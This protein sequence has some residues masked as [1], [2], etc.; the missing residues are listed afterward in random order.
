MKLY[1]IAFV[2]RSKN[3]GPFQVTIDLMFKDLESYKKIMDSAAFNVEKIGEL[4]NVAPAD[5]AIKPFERILTVKVVLPRNSSSGS[6]KDTDVYGSQQ[7]F[8]LA[9]LEI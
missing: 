7:H 2:C 3:A 4:Y 6:S 1:D 9:N 8:P 5:I